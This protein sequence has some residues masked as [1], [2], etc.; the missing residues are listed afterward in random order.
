MKIQTV[1]IFV[2]V[3]LCASQVLQAQSGMVLMVNKGQPFTNQRQVKVSF[4]HP[5]VHDKSHAEMR[6]GFAA[7]LSEIAWQPY[8]KTSDLSLPDKE[9][10]QTIYA[11]IKD[12]EGVLSPMVDFTIVYD[13]TA[14]ESLGLVINDKKQFSG[15]KDGKVKLQLKVSENCE[16]QVSND[17]EFKHHTHW[18]PF[19]PQKLWKISHPHQEGEK[20]VYVRY[21][22]KAGN[23][24]Q[25]DSSSVI[26]DLT[27]PSG[28][29]VIN[30]GDAHT[31]SRLVYLTIDTPDRDVAE[32][33]V[34]GP[35][36]QVFD[37]QPGTAG[38]TESAMLQVWWLDSIQGKKTVKVWFKDEAG[39]IS[40]HF[41]ADDIFLDLIH[42]EKP[43][44][45][46]N[47]GDEFCTD[48][49][50]IVNLKLGTIDDHVGYTMMISND[51]LF[52]GS[53]KIGFMSVYPGWS[54]ESSRDGKKTVY[55]KVFNEAGSGSE[56]ARDDIIL[57]RTKPEPL[58][59]IINNAQE[60]TNDP[61]VVIEPKA[62][63][64][65]MVQISN[66]PN[67]STLS[68]W[69]PLEK[70]YSWRIID[71]EGEAKVYARFKDQ[72]GNVS[73]PIT[74]TIK[75][76]LTIPNGTVRINEGSSETASQTVNLSLSYDEDVREVLLA[77]DVNFKDA[78]WM[79]V[80]K[81]FKWT[82]FDKNGPKS[83]YYRFRDRAGNVSQAK[84]ALIN[85]IASNQN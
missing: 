38:T 80:R 35:R 36:S 42:P 11:Q 34:V 41:A 15:R 27:P 51:S 60:W 9:G 13:K 64:A 49:D 19:D 44:I 55:F 17:R 16:M 4:V 76:D 73:E 2:F 8:R 47:N 1:T 74:G 82:L 22:D 70:S 21:R 43:L 83:I 20:W 40:E 10:K 63:N 29:L 12:A 61:V 45:N 39:N 62:R 57:Y 72:A 26:Q 33:R 85:L 79:P 28:T 30:N 59:V 50:G 71:R 54:L 68:S 78:T 31:T 14:P 7:D 25:V 58:E 6:I 65:N 37:F 75:Y 18:E 23:V 53:E 84:R 77:N 81:T 5:H 48:E 52:R 46:I 66:N 67:F 69:R 56:T 32:I 3:F 24:S